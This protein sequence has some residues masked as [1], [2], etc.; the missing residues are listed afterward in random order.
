MPIKTPFHDRT[1]PLCASY[2][3]KEWAGYYAVCAYDWCHEP[4]YVA[5]RHAAGL[6][7]V[8][9]L[10]KYEISGPDAGRLL[11][12]VLCRDPRRMR[13]GRVAYTTWCDDHGK[14]LDDGTVTRLDESVFRLTSAEPTL[15]W[16]ERHARRLEVG[17]I[18][19]SKQIAALAVQG[20]S[21]RAVLAAATDANL[22][23]LRFF[24]HT[25]A[26]L[27]GV[28]VEITRT[29]YTGDLGYEV[30]CAPGHALAVWDALIAHGRPYGLRPAGLDAL[31]ITRV[32]AGFVLNGVDY[33]SARACLIDEQS[34]TP[35]ELDLAWTVQ[36][37]RDPFIGQA[38]IRRERL[39]GRRHAFVGLVVDEV[40]LRAL[41]AKRRLPLHVPSA[42]WR[43][44]RPVYDARGRQ[45]GRA[46][47]GA[48]SPTLKK[49]LAL[50]TVESSVA[51][52]GTDLRLEVTIEYERTTVGARVVDKPF[53]DPERKRA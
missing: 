35:D 34:S 10:Y 9:P 11:A 16:L 51:A 1:A 41:F 18:D 27:D 15:G 32:E 4:E 42:A 13:V 43:D 22:D 6:L 2:R 20:P 37:D 7:D 47:S 29:G 28:P 26:S 53:F 21:S 25:R 5:F 19:Q 39:D 23:A 40:E 44:A 52:T 38:A 49:N 50:A 8:S 33:T 3:W 45:V 17:L 48:F 12:R 31:D 36:L 24:A 30:W 14:V 46:T